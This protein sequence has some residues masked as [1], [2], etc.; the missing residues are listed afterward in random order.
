MSSAWN[1]SNGLPGGG[2]TITLGPVGTV[3]HPATTSRTKDIKI[4]RLH[5][6]MI[7]TPFP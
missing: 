5:V 3:A 7:F 4:F 2:I 6:L 1:T